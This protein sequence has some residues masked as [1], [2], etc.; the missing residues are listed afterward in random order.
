MCPI[1]DINSPG[2]IYNS[3]NN[4]LWHR[5]TLSLCRPVALDFAPKAN[6]VFKLKISEEL[7][8]LILICYPN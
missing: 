8:G 7:P 1:S 3:K 4:L 5:S 2:L 6:L